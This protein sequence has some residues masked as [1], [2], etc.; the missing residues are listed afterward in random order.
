MVMRNGDG[1]GVDE[2]IA[3][4]TNFYINLRH[5]NVPYGSSSVS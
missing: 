5:D 1:V 2:L 4:A 3:I